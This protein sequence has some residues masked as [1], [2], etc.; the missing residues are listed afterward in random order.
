MIATFISGLV[1]G[2]TADWLRTHYR[3]VKS[4]NQLAREKVMPM[5]KTTQQIH[6][7]AVYT[8]TPFAVH[9]FELGRMP[10]EEKVIKGAGVT[11]N[12][13][14]VKMAFHKPSNT[15][16]TQL[17]I[18][19]SDES[20]LLWFGMLR[21]DMAEIR[22]EVMKALSN[23]VGWSFKSALRSALK[24]TKKVA[25]TRVLR[26]V[27]SLLNDPRLKMIAST[28]PGVG[29]ALQAYG[30][31]SKLMAEASQGS[32]KALSILK[33]VK[34]KAEQGV[35]KPKRAF[36]MMKMMRAY[37]RGTDQQCPAKVAIGAYFWNKDY[38]SPL[39]AKFDTNPADVARATYYRGTQL[40]MSGKYR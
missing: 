14:R 3:L 31:A 27:N 26:G 35:E 8:E 21:T 12:V 9:S 15:L 20:N 39:S 32:Q 30:Q 22:R 11:G 13:A 38:R 25:S 19:N 24:M 36:Q 34:A 17:A 7:F 4:R 33:M 16:E 37:E 5:A 23:R 28:V 40:L 29:T 1:G 18:Y 2:L 6:D 10:G